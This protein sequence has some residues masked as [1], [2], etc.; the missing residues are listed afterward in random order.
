MRTKRIG[1]IEKYIYI[2]KTVTL[3]QLCEEF[4]VS[5][6]TIR[7]DIDELASKGLVKKIYG[8]VTIPDTQSMKPFEERSISNLGLKQYIAKKAASL[9]NDG[10]I[11]F[12]DSGTTTFPMVEFIQKK[13][14]TILTNNIEVIIKCIPHN[15]I[16]VISLSGI[17]DRKALSFTGSTA[18][19]VLQQYNISKAFLA[20]TGISSK[21]GATNSSPAETAIKKTAIE[22]SVKKYLLV[23]HTKFEVSS[24][25]TYAQFDKLD[26]IITDQYPDKELEHAILSAG[27]EIIL[28]DS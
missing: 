9:V 20:A 6:N 26:A 5:K 17:L 16:N 10:E 12:I 11:I 19:D 13:N 15:N 28:A 25:V 8:G 14:I 4:K 21:N 3:D 27:C 24:L 22:R 23:D 7:R 1:N 18:V 2:N